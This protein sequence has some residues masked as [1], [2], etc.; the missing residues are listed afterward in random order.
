ML[1]L[2][3]EP[4][5]HWCV[6]V[7]RILG[8]KGIPFESR[9]VGYHDKQALLAATG[10]DYVPALVDGREVVLWQAIPDW[11]EAKAPHPTL[12]PGGDPGLHR[13]LEDWAHGRLEEMVWRVVVPDMPATIEDPR[14]RW[15]F[16]EIQVLKRGPLEA[17]RARRPELERDLTGHLAPLEQMLA[18]RPFLL[19]DAPGLADFAVF[20]ALAPLAYAGHSI[21]A[22]CPRLI[23]WESRIA[24]FGAAADAPGP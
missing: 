9:R 6:K 19:A 10:Q 13:V 17:L 4:F 18:P 24:R 23:A 21:P 11:S 20:G 16:E 7:E 22:S 2:Y 12:Y 14:E 1:V 5:S 15:V 3:Q 8:A